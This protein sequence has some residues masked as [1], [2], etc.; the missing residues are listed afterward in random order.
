MYLGIRNTEMVP[1]WEYFPLE[2]IIGLFL[3][4][5]QATVLTEH[6]KIK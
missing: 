5:C 1:K 4:L 6:A 3:S 2:F